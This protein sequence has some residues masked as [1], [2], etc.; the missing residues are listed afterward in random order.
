MPAVKVSLKETT[1]YLL[2]LRSSELLQWNLGW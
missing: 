1:G 2:L